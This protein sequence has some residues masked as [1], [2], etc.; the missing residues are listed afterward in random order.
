MLSQAYLPKCVDTVLAPL[1]PE[2]EV[3]VRNE[4]GHD[5]VEPLEM[6]KGP[7]LPSAEAV[8]QH[9][10]LHIHTGHGANGAS[11]AKDAVINTGQA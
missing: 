5:D 8:E 10:R 1:E 9:R 11:W 7:K 6:A 4:E 3:E 2:E